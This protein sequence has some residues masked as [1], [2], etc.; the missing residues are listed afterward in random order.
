MNFFNP[1][2]DNRPRGKLITFYSE[3]VNV[4]HIVGVKATAFALAI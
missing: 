1:W 3:N 4:I 2:Y